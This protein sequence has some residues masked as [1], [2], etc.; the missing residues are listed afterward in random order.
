MLGL[1]APLQALGVGH[2]FA[3]VWLQY[4]PFLAF[5]T[6]DASDAKALCSLPG[7]ILKS[8]GV[9]EKKNG[10]KI[11]RVFECRRYAWGWKRQSLLPACGPK[12]VTAKSW[13]IMVRNVLNV[14]RFVS[15]KEKRDIMRR[16]AVVSCLIDSWTVWESSPVYLSLLLSSKKKKPLPS[17]SCFSEEKKNDCETTWCGLWFFVYEYKYYK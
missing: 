2:F 10:R 8:S 16:E 14:L 4:V 15:A 3:G 6:Q 5:E 1:S 12:V 7:T 13:K 17:T 11:H 9:K